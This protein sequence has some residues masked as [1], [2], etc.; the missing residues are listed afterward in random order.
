M[1]IPYHKSGLNPIVAHMNKIA[2]FTDYTTLKTNPGGC[3]NTMD[4]NGNKVAVDF[5]FNE[6]LRKT[7]D[8]KATVR[9]YLDWCSKNAY[10]PRFAEFAWHENYYKL[11]E[12]FTLY[13]KDGI[14]VPQREV[15]A[16]FPTSDSAFGSMKDL[17]K[18]GLEEDAVI[19]GKRDSSLS[20]IV[21]EIQK[22]IPRTEAEILDEEV[23]QADRDLESGDI[24]FHDRNGNVKQASELT[25]AD[26]MDLLEKV[27]NRDLEN[28]TYIP[29]RA[30]T[31]QFFI[32]VVKE[33]SNG[34]VNPQN[35]PMAATVEHVAQNMDE[36][37]GQSYG[38]ERPHGLSKEDVVTIAKG[39]GHPSYIV[40][41]KNG[42][43]AEVVSFYNSKNRKVVVS[44]D[45]ATENNN[46][47]YEEYM[48]GY[49]GGYYNIIVTQFEPDS[50][51]NYL[52]NN[53][54]VYDKS[55]M[56]GRYQ[57]GSG[58]IV[59]VTHDTPFID[60]T[61]AQKDDY[62]KMY[63]SRNDGGMSN[64]QL[65][66]N[67]LESSVQHE[68][69][70]KR[71]AEYKENIRKV[72]ELQMQLGDL[73]NQI[74]ELSFA[75]GARDKEKL[76]ELRDEKI[77]TENRI[78]VID[79][80]LLRLESMQAIKNVLERERERA[81]KA[82]EKKGRAALDEYRKSSEKK[83]REI[84]DQYKKARAD[85]VESRNRTQYREKI[86]KMADKFHRMATAPS[87]RDTAHAPIAM[88]NA[89]CQ[90]CSVFAESE[91]NALKKSEYSLTAREMQ[92]EFDNERL[93]VTKGRQKEAEIINRIRERND[94]KNAAISEMLKR[95]AEIKEDPAFA[96]FYDEHVNN[97][98][99]DLS[100]QLGGT[101]IYDMNTEQLKKVYNTMHAMMHT[102][103]NANRVFSMEKDKTLIGV[104]R[105]LGSEIDNSN[106]IISKM[107]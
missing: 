26:F 1:V 31:P 63:S 48:N 29:M 2:E 25:E 21:D 10:T 107:Y 41:Q 15:R 103:T 72:S 81:R 80:A 104:T 84:I 45:F 98:L 28:G 50:I 79:G 83:Q 93:G 35:I 73:N 30:T 95:Y 5:N 34:K 27:E 62:V 40:K 32:D 44:V 46:Y 64:R 90:F 70:A 19:E 3:Q 67:A 11:M 75:K 9:Q 36:E 78:S 77:K 6:V 85:S 16:V 88:M 102:I 57:V 58:R 37:D 22:K 7:G 13:D 91:Q 4:K 56:N 87:K 52:K 14:Y 101:N 74:K 92:L 39:M 47:K 42:R 51:S 43:Y 100:K 24:M 61:V 71:L 53:E 76:R 17:I 94:K 23:K 82:A 55:K 86:H 89:L 60:D 69:E 49:N 38:N 54:V 12:D 105:K 66:A 68:V 99:D 8:P 106:G 96:M 65:L 20:S 33:H 18:S 59:A 97:L